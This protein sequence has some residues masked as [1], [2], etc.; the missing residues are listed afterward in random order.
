MLRLTVLCVGR[1]AGYAAVAV[2]DYLGRLRRYAPA[3]LVAVR[4]ERDA[5]SDPMV[6][7]RREGARLLEKAP[8]GAHRIALD[9]RGK[10]LDSPA[11]AKM[12][13]KMVNGGVRD[14]AFLVGGP[15]G[16]ADE[17]RTGAGS[18][19]SLSPLTLPHELA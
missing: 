8:G 7:R 11:F 1:P 12:L 15:H 9:P 2:D 5:D 4:A 16:L 19:L 10:S 13:E 17:V 3:E 18:L 14:C 6:A